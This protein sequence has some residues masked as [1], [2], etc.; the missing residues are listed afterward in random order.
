[1]T[2]LAI[3]L[4]AGAL[5]FAPDVSAQGLE[6]PGLEGMGI[7]VPEKPGDAKK[8]E[9]QPAEKKEAEAEPE[10][11][12]QAE[13]AAPPA[14]PAQ[15][16]AAEPSPPAAAPKKPRRPKKSAAPKET[17]PKPSRPPRR[18]E[19][20]PKTSAPPAPPPKTRPE[21]ELVPEAPKTTAI[22]AAEAPP[23]T[24]PFAETHHNN[25]YSFKVPRGWKGP[26]AVDNG[27]K[28]AAPGGRAFFSIAFHKKGTPLWKP[29]A[30]FRR[31]LR[32]LG[33]VT[34]P[35][36]LEDTKV[37]GV[38]ASRAR[39]TTHVFGGEVLFGEKRQTFYT[40][41]LVAPVDN[42]VYEIRYRS[43]KSEFQLNRE[44]FFAFLKSLVL[45]KPAGYKPEDY[46]LERDHLL[47]PLIEPKAG[48]DKPVH[49]PTDI[50]IDER[51]QVGFGLGVPSGL[52]IRLFYVL[53][54]KWSFGLYR[55]LSKIQSQSA[56]G[57][58]ARYFFK[59]TMRTSRFVYGDLAFAKA[60]FS[61]AG[62]VVSKKTSAVLPGIGFGYQRFWDFFTA[63]GGLGFVLPPKFQQTTRSAAGQESTQKAGMPISL[64]VS[65][66]WRF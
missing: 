13:E 49:R 40:E 44:P 45:P 18:R 60:S 66:S 43:V 20:R 17:K 9:T 10:P 22:P 2:W 3:L 14:K 47:K 63:E 48:P 62:D 24:S 39:Y 59:D 4:A 35:K 46:Y 28:Y 34:D 38:F 12:A 36:V 42:G 53:N 37:S 7:R 41:E 52:S 32:E 15:P 56:T 6:L 23:S 1:M 58:Q 5:C 27:V 54:G 51:F 8:D 57:L 25:L 55:S 65:G 31:E 30:D 33:D 61:G 19:R 16:A 11:P 26:L 64:F 29:P 21:E 50:L